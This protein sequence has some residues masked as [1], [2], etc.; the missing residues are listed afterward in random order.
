MYQYEKNED[1]KAQGRTELEAAPWDKKIAPAETGMMEV[2]SLRSIAITATAVTAAIVVT[3]VTSA[4]SFGTMTAPVAM[5][6]AMGAG[7]IIT[8]STEAAFAAADLAGGFKN[9][10]QVGMELGVSV[11]TSAISA[12][13]GMAGAAIKGLGGIGGALLKTGISAGTLKTSLAGVNNLNMNSKIEK[14]AAENKLKNA[15][16][17]MRMQYG[18]GD[19]VQLK[20]LDDILNGK[21]VLGI[22]N[23][24]GEAQTDMENGK[25]TVYLNNYKTDMTREE[26]L[27]IGIKLG[28]EAY[29]DGIVVT[30]EEQMV[31][32]RMAVNGHTEMASK[33]LGDDMYTK[34]MTNLIGNNQNL[35][36]D[37]LA[38]SFG[39]DVFNR[40]VDGTYDSSA[41]Y[42]KLMNDG[43]LSYD[44]SG[45]LYDE[46]GNLI[47]D[48]GKGIQGGLQVILDISEE[49]AY[50]LLKN[51]KFDI[52]KSKTVCWD[53]A[54][55]EGK[56]IGFNNKLDSGKTYEELYKTSVITDSL[57][58]YTATLEHQNPF[59]MYQDLVNSG[60]GPYTYDSTAITSS[61]GEWNGRLP[62]RQLSYEEWKD[63]NY[64]SNP[65]LNMITLSNPLS[66]EH[67][68][69]SEFGWRNNPFNSNEESFHT[70][71]DFSTPEGT[72]IY[73]MAD[74]TIS[75]IGNT[76]YGGNTIILE[77]QLSYNYKEQY[78]STNYFTD[79][80]HIQTN[81]TGS[82]NSS[83]NLGNTVNTNNI[84]A[85]S[86]NTGPSTGPHLHTGI[87]F[88]SITKNPYANWLYKK[89]HIEK[90]NFNNWYGNTNNFMR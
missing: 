32:T 73:P 24:N 19:E 15:A 40:Y 9:W 61:G 52:D 25:R 30:K 88:N 28:H 13:G 56:K 67:T 44:G 81:S 65:S 86:G 85:Y 3:A 82:V 2:P 22:G 5:L 27:A 57:T 76:N 16:T 14:A 90:Q 59:V 79:Y 72:P 66:G 35:Q 78:I 83:F 26:Q 80:L 39:D 49:E 50:Q 53:L 75:F 89:G 62:I 31:E 12:A 84:L 34:T 17:A 48:T 8:L 55:N 60:M 68:V 71:T 10:N 38:K 69:T 74:G 1:E 37:L 46:N 18:F 58:G 20:Q 21:T 41:D 64:I 36:M 87:H 6:T 63:N 29:R 4:L 45:N 54:S 77:H 23:V 47:L 33:M 42:W 70:G 11:A 7:A 51:S 43:T